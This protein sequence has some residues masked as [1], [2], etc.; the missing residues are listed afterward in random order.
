MVIVLHDINYACAY[1]DHIVTMKGGKIGPQ[2][3][4][5]TLVDGK[6][7]QDIFGTDAVFHKVGG[8][9]FVGV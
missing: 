4:A 1:A 6:L 3:D 2:G 8:R 9:T 7:M 5:E